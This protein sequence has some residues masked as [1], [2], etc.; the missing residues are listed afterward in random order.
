[1]PR[2]QTEE[3]HSGERL[4]GDAAH[5]PCGAVNAARHV[6]RHD[7]SIDLVGRLDQPCELALDGPGEPCPEQRI[8]DDVGARDQVG[9]ER[10]DL[11]VEPPGH[12]GGIGRKL[13]GIA[14]EA[15][16]YA[17]AP[18]HEVTRSHE[19]VPAVIAG[20]AQHGDG[21]RIG[22]AGGNLGGD[23]PPRILHEHG[24]SHPAL[25]GKA[26]GTAHFLC[27]QK[28]KHGVRLSDLVPRRR[29]GRPGKHNS[30]DRVFLL[31]F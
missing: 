18:L 17:I 29:S 14:I 3:G 25:D 1:M 4:D 31:Y 5:L 6:D 27:G 30:W 19:P 15:E 28:L 10:L 21:R 22:K 9:A 26:V 24:T 13:G 20:T 16:A 8:D 12:D 23:A 11:S 7:G 2:L